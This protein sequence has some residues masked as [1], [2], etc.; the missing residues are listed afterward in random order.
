MSSTKN[1][2]CQLFIGMAYVSMNITIIVPRL[3]ARAFLL[4][5]RH[6]IAGSCTENFGIFLGT[7]PRFD[8]FYSIFR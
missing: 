5:L 2:E 6:R 4:I 7:F 8:L 3:S 1:V